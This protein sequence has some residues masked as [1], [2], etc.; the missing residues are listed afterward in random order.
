MPLGRFIE[1]THKFLILVELK[2]S[3]FEGFNILVLATEILS[4]EITKTYRQIL[5]RNLSELEWE[6]ATKFLK[7]K[8]TIEAK[9]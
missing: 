8:L 3:F 4:V 2:Q 1:S 9:L 5:S 6:T 7:K